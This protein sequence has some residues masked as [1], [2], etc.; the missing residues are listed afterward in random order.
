ME[1]R[2][3]SKSLNRIDKVVNKKKVNSKVS[4]WCKSETVL[5]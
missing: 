3:K 1:S 2:K 4:E 5:A